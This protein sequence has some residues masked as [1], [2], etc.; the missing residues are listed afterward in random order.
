MREEMILEVKKLTKRYGKLKALDQVS[1]EVR[2]GESIALWGTNGAGKTTLLRSVL[3]IIPYEGEIEVMGFRV[4]SQG[5]EV[6]RRIGYI[7]QEI[8]F[9]GDQTVW[10]TISFYSRLR[11]VPFSE[12]EELLSDWGLDGIQHQ[13]VQTLS[14]G[15]KQKLGL[16]IALLSN[17]P[18][19]LMDEPT[20][21]LDV[22][23]RY[24]FHLLL[25]ELKHSGKTF[26]FCSHRASE[27]LKFADRIV[28]LKSGVKLLDGKP[29]EVKDYLKG[30]TLRRLLDEGV[31]VLDFEVES[32]LR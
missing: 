21:N 15:M 10:E 2:A 27:V 20:S 23:A 29:K 26:I 7:P 6:R 13:R 3:G 9:H 28:V 11:N 18:I 25:E 17:P 8:R 1:F 4:A 16:V 31:S 5:K 19:L 32:K 14:G 22:N 12:A 24:E 30:E